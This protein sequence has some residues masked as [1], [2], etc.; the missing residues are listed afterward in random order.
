MMKKISL[1]AVAAFLLAI[2]H[3]SHAQQPKKVPRIGYLSP[4][5]SALTRPVSS[6]FGWDCVSVA[7]SKGKNIAFEYRY[8]EGKRDRLPEARR[9]TS[10]SQGRYYRRSRQQR[11]WVLAA[12]NAT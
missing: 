10:A 4:Q 8:Q 11:N 9:R 5:D 12:K 1:G 3:L 2:S 6:H 7:M